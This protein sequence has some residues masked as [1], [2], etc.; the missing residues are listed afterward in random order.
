[1]LRRFTSRPHR[2]TLLIVSLAVWFA[3]LPSL[4][5]IHLGTSPHWFCPEH[6]RYEELRPGAGGTARV[7]L[8]DASASS[9]SGDPWSAL[10]TH[11]RCDIA[12]DFVHGS[13]LSAAQLQ[14]LPCSDL[15]APALVVREG[16]T[17]I[18]VLGVAPKHS[19]PLA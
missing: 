18:L 3:A 6:L 15:S 7:P 5:V 8:A 9:L 12:S 10:R 2:S 14:P 19:P 13:A 16:F 11:L 1:M 17:P 4:A